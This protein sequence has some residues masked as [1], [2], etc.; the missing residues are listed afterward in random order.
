M[1]AKDVFAQIRITSPCETDWD[2]MIGNDRIR[3]CRHC[4]L[5]VH[6][7][8][9]MTSKEARRLVARSQGRL[10]IRYSP[11]DRSVHAA[12]PTPILH[13]IGRRTS[14]L[15]AGAFSV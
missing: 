1:S 14:I 12:L 2:S 4:Q 9:L 10:C 15:A 8:L 11:L 7:L 5:S 6:N 13:G 3:F